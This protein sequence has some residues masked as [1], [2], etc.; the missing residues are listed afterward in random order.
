[1]GLPQPVE[2]PEETKPKPLQ[3]SEQ[4]VWYARSTVPARLTS[5]HSLYERVAQWSYPWTRRS[6]PGFRRGLMSLIGR[7]VTWGAIAHWRAG[8]RRLPVD[9]ALAHAEAIEA[10]CHSGLAIAAELR[11]YIASEGKII[12]RRDGICNVGFD[13]AGNARSGQGKGGRLY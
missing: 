7:P 8:R 4:A 13:A 5:Y 9:V 10:R 2:I 12:R 11:D 6:Y 1:M 3:G